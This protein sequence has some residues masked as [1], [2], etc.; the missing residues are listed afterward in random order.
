[1]R[2]SPL[3]WERQTQKVVQQPEPRGCQPES[4]IFRPAGNRTP[5][6]K[7]QKYLYHLTTDSVRNDNETPYPPSFNITPI[8]SL[9]ALSNN[10]IIPW[11]LYKL[12]YLLT[13]VRYLI[14]YL[15][16]LGNASRLCKLI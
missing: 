2:V 10:N 3:H 12:E 11:R 7:R 4:R 14:D 6:V 16:V 1:M 5:G 15:G 8:E 13:C 9:I